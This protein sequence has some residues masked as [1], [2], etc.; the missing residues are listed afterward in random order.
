MSADAACVALLAALERQ[1][2][3][4]AGETAWF[5]LNLEDNVETMLDDL[6]NVVSHYE[7]R[8]TRL[9]NSA[10]RSSETKQGRKIAVEAKNAAIAKRAAAIAKRA[11]AI[12]TARNPRKIR[13]AGATR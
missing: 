1:T 10:R 4:T 7:S 3:A 6:A 9:A 2:R 13:R 5:R 8:L 11:A 12:V